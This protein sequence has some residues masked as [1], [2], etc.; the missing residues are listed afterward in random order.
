[1]AQNETWLNHDLSSAVKVQYLDGNLFSMDNAGNLIGVILTKDGV[2]YSGGGTVSANVIRADGGTVAVTGAL[3]GNV[4]TVVLPQA[5]YAVPGVAS[6]VVKLTA[7]GE[8]TTIGAVVA[9]VYESTTSTTIDPGTIIPSIQTLVNQINTAVS[10]IP[11]DYS[12]LWTSLAPAFSSSTAYTSGQY[13]TYDGGLYRFVTD[14]AAGSWSSSDVTAAKL[15]N[16]IS[17]LKS[18]ITQFETISIKVESGSW[19]S[20]FEKI[21]QNRR[22][23]SVGILPKELIKSITVP[24]GYQANFTYMD[25]NYAYINYTAWKEGTIVLDSLLPA[26]AKAF[27]MV[28]QKKGATTSDISADVPTVQSAISA[29]SI[30]SSNNKD[31][32]RLQGAF[33]GVMTP[34][35]ENG[36]YDSNGDKSERSDR[37]RTVRQINGE[38]G[39]IT[40]NIGSGFSYCLVKYAADGT[41]IETTGYTTE[42]GIVYTGL[43]LFRICVT[44]YNGYDLD[45]SDDVGLGIYG[46]NKTSVDRIENEIITLNNETDPYLDKILGF[47]IGVYGATDE[48]EFPYSPG[49][50]KRCTVKFRIDTPCEIVTKNS[51]YSYVIQTQN[52]STYEYTAATAWQYGRYAISDTT[53]IYYVTVQ[54]G[55]AVITDEV[56]AIKKIVVLRQKTNIIDICFPRYEGG[57]M[58]CFGDSYTAMERWQ[59]TVVK[60]LLLSG[61]ENSAISGGNLTGAFD[62]I[63]NVDANSKIITVWYGTN[64]YANSRLLGDVTT[65][66]AIPGTTATDVYFW[67]ALKYVCEWLGANRKNARVLFITHTQ[68]WSTAKDLEFLEDNGV[69]NRGFIKN[70]RGYSLEDYTNA[71]VECAHLY[72][73]DVLDLFHMGEVNK[74]NGDAFYESDLLH[75]TSASGVRIGHI[76]AEKLRTMN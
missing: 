76:V 27:V 23:R 32:D 40:I 20:S 19:N 31:F 28:I 47:R 35:M 46:I 2:A 69:N 5:A 10:S 30:F 50:N 18:A 42:S 12:A 49:N 75:P 51:N 41:F 62:Q 67:G 22:I 34:E 68:R 71:V 57:L 8:V 7:S 37:L 6:V 44:K 66:V 72:G 65:P 64:D 74:F 29:E 17:D 4:A 39:I 48:S 14:H 3:S 16:D 53:K 73:Y 25:K 11:A 58:S 1:M 60:D 13:V 24:S 63:S 56:E 15:G 21:A 61:Y 52:P 70:N 45:P 9:N 43:H 55:N 38:D 36:E 59:P 33:A 26:S 54:H